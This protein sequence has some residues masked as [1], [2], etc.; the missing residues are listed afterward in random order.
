MLVW[1]PRS[2][3][4]DYELQKEVR[5][6]QQTSVIQGVGFWAMVRRRISAIR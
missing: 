6:L 3:G 4:N 2:T 1:I 5:G